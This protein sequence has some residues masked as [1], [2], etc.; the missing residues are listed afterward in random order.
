MSDRLSM[1]FDL[2][3]AM[4]VRI[5]PLLLLAAVPCWL[6]ACTNAEPAARPRLLA[7]DAARIATMNGI[8]TLEDAEDHA[9]MG[10]GMMNVRMLS[11][12]PSVMTAAVSRPE[13]ARSKTPRLVIGEPACLSITV[14]AGP[15]RID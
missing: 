5:T 14:T 10:G 6:A 3:A 7:S 2:L 8:E 15:Q 4:N 12:A 1:L 11:C 9:G 13:A